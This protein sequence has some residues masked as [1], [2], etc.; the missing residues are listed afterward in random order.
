[1]KS[2]ALSKTTEIISAVFILLFVY[3]AT[4]K[5]LAHNAFLITLKETGVIS[6]ASGFLSWTIPAIEIIISFLLLIPNYRTIGLMSSFGL[7]LLFTI[8]IAYMLITSSH[9]PCSCGGIIGKLSWKAHLWLNI[10]LTMLAATAIYLN[11]RPKFLL[12]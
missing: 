1:M 3:T 4:S 8:Y 7:M 6:F 12:Q 11:K 5:L 2:S 9:L 10:F